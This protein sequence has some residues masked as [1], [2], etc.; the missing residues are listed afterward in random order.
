MLQSKAANVINTE[1]QNQHSVDTEPQPSGTNTGTR[2]RSIK[3]HMNSAAQGRLLWDARRMST[4]EK[5]MPLASEGCIFSKQHFSRASREGTQGC[6]EPYALAHSDK[7][8]RSQRH[9][10]MHDL[11]LL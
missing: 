5:K 2:T 6:G 11:S 8:L 3:D 4:S 9:A 7:A 10:I 1:K